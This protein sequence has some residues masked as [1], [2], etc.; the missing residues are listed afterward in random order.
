M[1]LREASGLLRSG[2]PAPFEVVRPNAASP[3]LLVCEHA[4]RAVPK[5]L[6]D[7]GVPPARMDR[8]IAS[9]I[10]AEGLTRALS[11]RLDATA[12]LQPYSRLVIDCNRPAHAPD[13][14]PAVSDGVPIPANLDLSETGRAARL[15]AIHGPFHA[16]VA[17][18]L[19]AGTAKALVAIHSFT[20]RLAEGMERPWDAGFC[21]NRDCRLARALL[22]EV[23]RLAPAACLALNEPYGVDDAGDHT[24]PVHGEARGLPH[25]LV[26]VRNDRIGDAAGQRRCAGL[27]AAALGRLRIEEMAA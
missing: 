27:L 22:V 14:I 6:G 20:P 21:C 9:D 2:D 18:I 25:V 8:H 3:W 11:E 23:S 24:I 19:D 26:E 12:V 16:A 7:L 1:G 4:G 17:A 5:V 13:L 10:G 15:A